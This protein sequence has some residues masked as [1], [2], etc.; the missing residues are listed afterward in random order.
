MTGGRF[1]RGY[2]IYLRTEKRLAR[3][4]VQTYAGEIERFLAYAEEEG[5]EPEG[6]SSDDILGYLEWRGTA[7][8]DS[9]TVARII[10]SLNS[11]H[12][13]LILEKYRRENPLEMVDKPRLSRHLPEVLQ[14]EEVNRFLQ[15]FDPDHPL[16]LRDR[17]LFELIYSCGLRVSEAAALETDQIFLRE[18]LIRILGKGD[19]ERL[20]PLGEEAVWWLQRYMAEA[21]PRLLRAGSRETA[22]FLN[23]RGG[24][25]SRKGMWKRFREAADRA[26]ISGKI[27]TLRHSFA[28]HL[29][30]GGADLRSVQELLGHADIAT[31]QIYTHLETEHLEEIHKEFHPRGGKEKTG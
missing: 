10:S 26:G 18:G 1:L 3:N 16:G 21:R 6:F 2:T 17:A 22:V 19:K 5:L 20:V 9:R 30:E 8:M 31:T 29:L 12:R 7:R 15:Q 14:P 24:G 25:F 4:T 27:H 28:T 13:Y 23:R 11:F